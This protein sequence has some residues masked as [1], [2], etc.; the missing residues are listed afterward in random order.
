MLTLNT[1]NMIGN[2]I[3]FTRRE[4]ENLIE[5]GFSCLVAET[6]SA[7]ESPVTAVVFYPFR[8][9]DDA[10][11][12]FAEEIRRADRIPG[13]YHVYPIKDE[14]ITKLIDGEERTVCYVEYPM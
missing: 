3:K 12:L 9:E 4:L 10:A 11:A 14:E 8:R 13:P 7:P 1:G 2:R 6:L 5:M